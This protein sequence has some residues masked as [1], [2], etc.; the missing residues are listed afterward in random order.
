MVWVLAMFLPL[1]ELVADQ[2]ADAGTEQM[3]NLAFILD[4]IK[5]LGFSLNLTVVLLTMLTFFIL[6]GVAKFFETYLKVILSTI[7]HSKNSC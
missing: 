6:K 1:L 7:F 5:A 3:G 2:N 4:G